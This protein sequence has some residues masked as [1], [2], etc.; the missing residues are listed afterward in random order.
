MTA[1][2]CPTQRRPTT[3]LDWSSIDHAPDSR[4]ITLTANTVAT[5]TLDQDYAYA[6]VVNVDGA[7]A[8]YFTVNGADPTVKGNGTLVLPAVIDR[9]EIQPYGAQ[10]TTV[11]LISA[12]T[13]QVSVMGLV[14]M[15]RASR[16]C[17]A[18]GCPALTTGGR[19]ATHARPN[20][21][22]R[23]YGTQH[24]RL[25]E[26]W[27]PSAEAGGGWGVTPPTKI[28]ADRWEVARCAEC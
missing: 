2:F 24:R 20:A 13:P 25:R 27:R 8:V 11:K 10:S 7:A 21:S 14:T 19:C 5:V 18:D 15:T 12:G 3:P 22:T 16:V 23:G 17:P 28:D 6:E 1:V 9:L 4:H 26:Q